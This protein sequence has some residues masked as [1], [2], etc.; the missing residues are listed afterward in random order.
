MGESIEFPAEEGQLRGEE[1][2]TPDEV[3][4]M[5]R[6]KELGWG[7]RRDR[8]DGWVQSSNCSALFGSEGMSRLPNA[9][10]GEGVGWAG[11]LVGGTVSPP[12]WQCRC[13]A[14]GSGA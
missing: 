5:V 8:S 3:A 7:E 13:C 14:S 1:M 10:A 2:R 4:A 11:S 9:T 6:L 12:S